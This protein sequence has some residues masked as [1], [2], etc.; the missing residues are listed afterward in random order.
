MGW[1]TGRLQ[2]VTIDP[3][4]TGPVSAIRGA[5]AELVVRYAVNHLLL[6]MARTPLADLFLCPLDVLFE[7]GNLLRC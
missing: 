6:A 1:L 5:R 2:L 7:L 4:D 3:R